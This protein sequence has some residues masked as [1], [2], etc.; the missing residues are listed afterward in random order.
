MMVRIALA[1]LLI[2]AAAPVAAEQLI[3]QVSRREVNI[4]SS[5]SGEILTMFGIVAPDTGT[6]DQALEGPYHVVV[7]VT[8]PLQTRVARRMT[9][10]FGIWL[11]TTEAQF[12]EFPSLYQVL[13]DAK[14]TD[15][16]EPLTLARRSVPLIAQARN[17]AASGWWNSLEFGNEL[18]RLMQDKGLYKLN[19]QGVTFR[20]NTFYFAQV[21]LPSDAPPGPYIAHTYLFKNGEI[22]AEASDGFSV[23]K[24][25]FERFV[26]QSARQFPLLYGLVCVALALFTG[27]LGGVVFK[28]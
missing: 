28:R 3:T 5:F 17:S 18:V 4:T 24:V 15:I 10:V 12:R 27:W 2:L 7:T 23:K 6:P 16:A 8:G 26:G 13:S 20:S 22:I 14:L 1:L 21:A 9:N 11:N 25:G 19:E